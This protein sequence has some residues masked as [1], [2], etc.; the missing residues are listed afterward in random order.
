MMDY[1]LWDVIENGPSL[2]KTQV[3]ECVTTLM[4]ITSI[5][6]KAQ[7]RL[8]VKETS[9]LMMGIPNEHQLKFNSIKDAKHL[10]EAIEKI[11]YL[12]TMIM[13]DLYNNLKV[14][15]PEVK[16]MSRSNS[17]I[18]NIAFVSLLNNNSTNGAVNTAQAVNTA[19]RVFTS[20]TQVKTTNIDNLSDAV[21]CAFLASQP[22]SPQ[23]VND[24]L[25][26]IHPNDLEEIDSRW[27]MAML[28][29]RARSQPSSPQLVNGDLEQIHPNNLEEID[30]RWQMAMLTMRA[31]RFLKKIGR[32]LIVI[33]L[34][35]CDSLGG[36]DWSD[37]AKEVPNYALM[38]YTSTNSDSK[39]VDNCKK[40]LGYKNYNA[41]PPPYTGNL[42][43]PKPNLS[44][45]RLDE[46]T[47]KPVVENYDAKTSE[48]NPKDIRK[49]NDALIIKE[50]VL[51][52][53]E[54]E[55][56]QPKIQ[57]KTVKPSIHKIEFVK[58]KKPKNKTRKTIKQ[59][60]KPRHNTH[61]PR[62][63]QRN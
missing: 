42:M 63:N 8:E 50:W 22:S 12:D 58:P 16:G 60:E 45:T 49:N 48:T 28:T 62:G 59:V 61:R 26:Q 33:D 35:S 14:Y 18:Q 7:T 36:Y 23:L 11:F 6:D 30:L 54:V 32:K 10:M 5:E 17:S 9:T 39:I 53:D 38:A 29:M 43:P 56:T 46:F 20:G 40:G 19:L 57:Q 3:M 41:I 52:D 2:P 51:D 1:A 27:Q 25:E 4:P 34:V 24:D 47:N 15:E 55:V 13:D 44:F 31:K 21:I 37:Q